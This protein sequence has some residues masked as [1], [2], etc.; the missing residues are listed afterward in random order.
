[1]LMAPL[2][3]P[4]DLIATAGPRS[5]FPLSEADFQTISQI[6]HE[7]CGIVLTSHKRE[8]VY[9]RLTQRLRALSLR[10]FADYCLLLKSGR[11]KQE[12]GFLIDAITTN[13][14]RFF[15]EAHHFD[16]LKNNVL[17][18]IVRAAQPERPRIKIWSAGCSTGEEPFS[19]AMA[20][21]D[22]R[23]TIGQA[24]DLQ[25]LATDLDTAVLQKAKAGK[26]RTASLE[27][28]PADLR[29]RSFVHEA[30]NGGEVT[31]S[32]NL[33]NLITFKQLNLL[34]PWPMTEQFDAIFCRNVMIYFD[35]KTKATL[36]YR[37][38]SILKDKGWLYIGHSESLLHQQTGFALRGRTIYQ[39]VNS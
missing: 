5:E 36:I 28:V 37:F 12:M 7:R 4:R 11:G 16:H 31:V 17:P 15:R 30:G 1:V 29:A 24:W 38:R 19:I 8:M 18:E 25:I 26:Y 20:A 22:A 35:A 34:E 39:K 13:L 10:S 27:E 9:A 2:I 3:A 21:V 33:R 32:K 23:R 6:V 14:T